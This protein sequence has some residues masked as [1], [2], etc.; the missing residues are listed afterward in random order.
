[1]A[2]PNPELID[3]DNPEWTAQEIARARPATEL[4]STLFGADAAQDMFGPNSRL[5]RV[6]D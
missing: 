5:P 4:L 6:Q 2:E 1:M 3:E